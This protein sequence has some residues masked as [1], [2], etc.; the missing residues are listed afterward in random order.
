MLPKGRPGGAFRAPVVVFGQL[1]QLSRSNMGREFS[2][3]E[4][5]QP[6]AGFSPP[7]AAEPWKRRAFSPAT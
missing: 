7:W 1:R 5:E 3:V 6:D 4:P 2:P